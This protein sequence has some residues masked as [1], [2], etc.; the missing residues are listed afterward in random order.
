MSLSVLGTLVCD[1]LAHYDDLRK[2]IPIEAIN[3]ASFN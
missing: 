3:L 1:F 2:H